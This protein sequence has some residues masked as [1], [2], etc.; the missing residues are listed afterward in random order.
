MAQIVRVNIEARCIGVLPE[1]IYTPR[2]FGAIMQGKEEAHLTVEVQARGRGVLNG[3]IVLAHS[4]EMIDLR[5]EADSEPAKFT[6]HFTIN[7]LHLPCRDEGQ[8]KIKLI[9]IQSPPV[10]SRYPLSLNLS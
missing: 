9:S 7:S 4:G 5:P 8:V 6:H 1:L 3:M 2:S 10:S